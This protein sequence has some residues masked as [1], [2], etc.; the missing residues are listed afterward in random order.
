MIHRIST[1]SVAP[2]LPHEM[3]CLREIA[4]NVLWTWDHELLELF[5]SLDADLWE[6]TGHNPVQMLGR[7]RQ[8]VLNAALRDDAFLAQMQRAYEHFRDYVNN[9]S[10]WFQ[11]AFDGAERRPIAYFCAEFGIT[12]CLAIYSGGLG[13]LAGDHLRSASDLGVPIVGVGLLYQEGYFRQYLNADGWQQERYPENDFYSLPLHLTRDGAGNPITIAVEYPGRTVR[14]QIWRVQAGRVSLYLLDTNIPVNSP[15]DQ[16]I[17]DQLYGGDKEM[18]IKQEMMLGIGG[19][20]ALHALGLQPS[21]CHMNE[22]HSALMALERCRLLMSESGLSF[23][24]AREAAIAGTVFTT[25]TPVL[26]GNDYF[27]PGLVAKYL[28]TFA[29]QLNL[30]MRDLLALGRQNAD[31]DAEEFCMTILALRMA[32]HCNGV[33]R[34]HGKV[35]RQM[36]QNVWK[37][38]PLNEVPVTSITNGVHAPTWVSRDMTGLFTRYLGPRWRED[39]SDYV[40]WSRIHH[41]PDE[42]LWRTHERRRERLV[43]FARQRMRAQ[44]ESIGAPPAE[45]AQADEILD[46]EALTIGFARRFATYKRASLLLRNPERLIRILNDKSRPVQLIFAGKA[47]PQDAAGKELIRQIIHFARN[48]EVRR[49]IV[50]LEDYNITVG[51]YLVQGVDVWLNTPRRPLEASGTSG[52]KAALNGALNLS[53][54]DGWWDEAYNPELGWA[55]GCGEEYGDTAYEDEVESNALYNLLEKEIVPL[56]FARAANGLPRA[57]LS[58]MKTSMR[59]LGPQFN[60][61]RMVREYVEQFYLPSQERYD[62]LA[63]DGFQRAKKLVAWKENLRNHWTDLKIVEI[64]SNPGDSFKVGDVLEVRAYLKLGR[65]TPDDISVEIYQGPLDARGSITQPKNNP[66]T[67]T[68]SNQGDVIE[69]RGAITPDTSGRHGYTIRILPKNEDLATPLKEGLILWS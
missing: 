10:T 4:Y 29:T 5:M 33:S 11:K 28:A 47:H 27:N 60:A 24:E 62:A 68:G 50:F 59:I 41:I 64:K 15:E 36:W 54:L 25:H 57:W 56:F 39:P 12:E 67:P 6:A 8:E 52:M 16:D 58:K 40:L 31:N 55:I 65:I 69:F 46:P 3:E 21:V 48:P 53:I 23:P 61:K 7:I 42:E 13:L 66:M 35:S 49:R 2:S 1:F 37:D 9:R 45:V 38:L 32:R 44:L 20:R 43:A 14:A 19:Y 34:L 51:R 26:A 18:R 63:K 22:G 30:S 17:T